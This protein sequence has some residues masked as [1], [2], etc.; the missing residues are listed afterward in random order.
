MKAVSNATAGIDWSEFSNVAGWLFPVISSG[1]MQ[2]APSG[3]LS[4]NQ[5]Q[6]F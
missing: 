3:Q 6:L 1:S 4:A 2:Y 5:G